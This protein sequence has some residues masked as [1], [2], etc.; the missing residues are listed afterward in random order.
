MGLDP[1]SWALIAASTA[2]TGVSIYKSQQSDKQARKA[3]DLSRRQESFK[4]LRERRDF[5]RSARTTAAKVNQGAENAGA[6]MTSAAQGGLASIISQAGSGL[7]FLDQYNA[8]STQI[9]QAQSK[10]ARFASQANLWGGVADLAGSGAKMSAGGGGGGKAPT[11]KV[12][13]G[14]TAS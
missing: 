5:I 9:G 7:S 1:I 10:S 11:V 12:P 2:A 3:A 14:P 4:A 8:F 13:Y 6:S